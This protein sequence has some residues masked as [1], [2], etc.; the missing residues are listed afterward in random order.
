M[1]NKRGRIASLGIGVI[2]GK[3]KKAFNI[4]CVLDWLKNIHQP[5]RSES[6]CLLFPVEKQLLSYHS[7]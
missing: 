7:F 4:A 2:S 6:V 3:K 1:E 5:L